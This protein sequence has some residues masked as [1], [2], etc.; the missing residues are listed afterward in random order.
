L[1][2]AAWLIGVSK[3]GFGGGFGMIVTPMLASIMP[4]KTVVGFMLPLLFATDVFSLFHYWKRWNRSNIIQL[5]PGT[6]LG[7]AIGSYILNDISDDHLKKVIGGIACVFAALEWHR[8]R[9]VER[10]GAEIVKGFH[11]K[12]WHGVIAGV[13]TGIFSTLAHIGGL[14]VTMYLLPQR[15]SNQAFVGTTTALYFI[16]NFVKF[17]FYCA[18][19]RDWRSHEPA[20]SPPRF[21]SN[22]SLL[23]FCDRREVVVLVGQTVQKKPFSACGLRN[24]F[25]FCIPSRL[26]SHSSDAHLLLRMA[27]EFYTMA[28]PG[29]YRRRLIRKHIWA[30]GAKQAPEF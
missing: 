1:C 12:A 16:I 4:A 20:I 8:S 10:K 22:N 5:I 14:V 23:R 21:F 15:L 29:K 25:L 13:L 17:P 3:A 24:G 2:L 7:I 19:R 11:F 18:R 27:P 6:L 26:P 30:L 28:P 9:R